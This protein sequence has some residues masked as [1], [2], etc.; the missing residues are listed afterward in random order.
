MISKSTPTLLALMI[1]VALLAGVGSA[2]AG[3]PE[4]RKAVEVA[5]FLGRWY[6]FAHTPNARERACVA[7]S[8]EFSQTGPNRYALQQTCRKAGGGVQSVRAGAQFTDD[9]QHA[10]LD[11]LFFGGLIRSHYWVL[12]HDPDYR[13]AVVGT[14]G[15]RYVWILTREPHPPADQAQAA[16]SAARALGFDPAALT[17]P[18]G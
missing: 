16:K 7:G 14:S 11:V 5:R 15:G 9:R 17:Y 13:W 3:A 18:P 2:Q 1:G 12:D 8:M 4:P 6:E 10:K